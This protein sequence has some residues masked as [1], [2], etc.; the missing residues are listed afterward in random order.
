MKTAQLSSCSPRLTRLNDLAYNLRW[1]W[2]PPTRRLFARIAGEAAGEE[3]INPVDVLLSL[4]PERME[5]LEADPSF[6]DQL[7]DVTRQFDEYLTTDD[8]WFE[9]QGYSGSVPLVAYFSAEFGLS[10]Q[11][12]IYSGGL[13]VL[14]GDHLKSASA[15]GLP[16]TAVGLFYYD[17]YFRQT[18]DREGWQHDA[19]AQSD[20]ERLP[21]RLVR[22]D[23][24]T[25]I[26][27]EVEFPGRVVVARIWHV[28]VG[29]VSLYLMDTRLPENRPE[30]RAI[31]DRLYG[32]DQD[33]R[34]RQEIVL[35]IGGL[36]VLNALGLQP[37]VFHLNEGHSSF[38][39][40]ERIR[41]HMAVDG[42]SFSEA[43][44]RVSSTT[45]F[46]THTPVAAGHDY[47]S[48][49]V[50]S[51]YFDEFAAG[52]GL[53]W[54]DFLSLGRADASAHD[55]PF[56]MT[57]LA[58]RTSST[59]NG[60]SRLHGEVT[61]R[62]WHKLWPDVPEADVPVGYVTN[63][64]HMATWIAP[65]IASLFDERISS[66]W[67]RSPTTFCDW[68]AIEK[69]SDESLWRVHLQQKTRFIAT[70]RER[71]RQQL[72]HFGGPES[73]LEIAGQAL[74]PEALTIG[75]ARRFTAYKRATLLLSDLDRLASLIGNTDRPVQFVFAGKAHPRDMPGKQLIQRIASVSHLEPF[76]GR[77]LFLE[78]YD[79]AIARRMV[80]GVDVWLNNPTRP[81]EASGTS[82]MKAAA[83]GVLNFS[84]L[85]GWWAEAWETAQERGERIGWSIDPGHEY[86]DQCEQDAA[87]AIRLYEI[88]EQEI[89]PAFY[90][91]DSKGIPADW[92]S[93][94][95]ASIRC[96]IPDF[97]GVRMVSEYTRNYYLPAASSSGGNGAG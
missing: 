53:E 59:R 48:A 38:L 78:D 84:I 41:K 45:V 22:R 66:D 12:P 33:L 34:L 49:D 32:G 47:F 39:S 57:E 87:D 15:L 8:T 4:S 21:L 3:R 27:I 86:Q 96:A 93:L 55:A 43:L 2:D 51:Q 65:E 77:L 14:A 72:A 5:L 46:T 10:E 71:L 25:P 44:V 70:A 54:Q 30:D 56:G 20:T 80:A 61:R 69:I 81:Q 7:D 50:L 79:M 13:G 73:D 68:Q 6:L 19:D 26:T 75:F 16:L 89:I 35:G 67:K 90:E 60:V 94:M 18:I 97:G 85:D 82:G 74:D 24:G 95:K 52:L 83:N 58:M 62:M 76:K 11:L 36:R 63:G 17:G 92:I 40:L 88:L 29:R 91:R 28:V 9:R 42:I 1:T 23:D 64:V 37:A 31:C